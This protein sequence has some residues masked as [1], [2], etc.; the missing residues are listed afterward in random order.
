MAIKNQKLKKYIFSNTSSIIRSRGNAITVKDLIFNKDSGSAKAIVL[1]T[2]KYE[3]NFQGLNS[4]IILSS[5]TCPFDHGPVCKHEVAVANAIDT[6][7]NE[8]KVIQRT[9]KVKSKYSKNGVYVLF[10][11]TLEDLS[12][13]ILKKHATRTAFIDGTSSRDIKIDNIE[14]TYNVISAVVFDKSN[15]FETVYLTV[16][17]LVA[18]NE[19]RLTC[20]C[21]YLNKS[22][23]KHQITVLQLLKKEMIHF[24]YGVEKVNELRKEKLKEYGFS[25][26]NPKIEDF[27]EFCNTQKGI[28]VIPK[29]RGLM[30]LSE[31]NDFSEITNNLLNDEVITNLILPQKKK[32]N[33]KKQGIAI[34]VFLND[35]FSRRPEALTLVPLIG[36][37]NEKQELCTKISKIESNDYFID[38][39]KYSAE[40][41]FILE[42]V[43]SIT[44]E[45]L[46]NKSNLKD[47]YGGAKIII[48]VLKKLLPKLEG[49]CLYEI[50]KDYKISRADLRQIAIH[51][52]APELSFKLIEEEHFYVLESFIIIN[53][54]EV[55]L[56]KSETGDNFLLQQVKDDYYLVKSI[57]EAKTINFFK[58][59]SELRFLKSDYNNY[60]AKLIKPLSEKYNL[61]V[62]GLNQ[63]KQKVIS[64]MFKKQLFISVLDDFLIIKPAVGYLDETLLLSSK[65]QFEVTEKGVNFI[66]SRDIDF[67]TSFNEYI[68][69]LHPSFQNQDNE[70]FYLKEVE[71]IENT[72]FIGFFENLKVNNVEV[73]GL[74]NLKLKYNYNKPSISISVHSNIDWFDVNI[75]VS[76]GEEKVSLK[77]LKKSIIN[78]D[79]Y[80]RLKDGSIGILPEE[81]LEKYVHLFR[82]GEIKKE[83]IGVSKY[84]FSA[85][86]ILYED[87]QNENNL[88]DEYVIIKEKLAN[89]KAVKNVSQPKGLNAKLR[90]YQQEGLKWLNFLDDFKLGG[91]L[92]DDMGLGKTLQIISFIKHLKNKT[93]SK[94]PHLVI[95]PTSLIFNWNEEVK[96]FCPSLKV[97]T[98]SGSNRTKNT[99]EFKNYDIILTTYGTAINDISYLKKYHFNYIILDES[100]AIK[101]PISKR[102]KAVRLLKATNRL[103]LTGTPIENN[104][105][106]L[107]A[108]M[109]FVNPGLLGGMIHFKK[110]YATPIDKNKDKGVAK[111]LKSLI[112]P[113]L[114]R[115]TKNQVAK[116]LPPKT[117]QFLYCTM[118][119]EQRKLYE[120][121][122]NKYKDYLLGKIEDDGLG[123]SKIYVL[124]GLTKLRQICDSPSL[125]NDVEEY[126]NES[127]KI[128]ELISHI[129]H[130]TNNHKILIFSQ[131]VKMLKLIK[132]RLNALGIEYEYLDGK[133]KNRQ[134]K[135]HN[136]QNNDETRVF[137][138]SLKAGGTG[139]NLTAADYVYIVDPWWNPAVEAQAIDRCYRIGQQ[140]NVTAFKMIC[141]D[142]IEEKIVMHQQNKKE[143]SDNLIQTEDNFVKS[144]SK[145]AIQELFS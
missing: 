71:F 88:F 114:L 139:L 67:E 10:F 106:D 16:K 74:D 130:K 91:C 19:L 27:F 89:F 134:E 43:F 59:K 93:K 63:K 61:E 62:I 100:Q 11:N 34:G 135:V 121:Y 54:K 137:L 92:A 80:I 85:V 73:F 132:N 124:E 140:K 6:K 113:F 25:I 77:D 84:Q 60:D 17:V 96:K 66:V 5:C 118:G 58:K 127:V 42:A 2:S 14:K 111:E 1:G 3:V 75:T 81:W 115:R 129:T 101:N 68:K 40:E 51:R 53:G 50:K 108:Q 103:V 95:V 21:N 35:N 55:K 144:L 37:L 104:T 36:V 45:A 110:E 13:V 86:D 125:L 126:T 102:F 26:E 99:N 31:F 107:Y 142:T 98:L 44:E 46:Q 33:H 52:E 70:F 82:S 47:T 141:K 97:F 128:D 30:R 20:N 131:F 64:S 112:D 105:F 79:K 12:D 18:E 8:Q 65:K 72:W 133:T 22:L 57:A 24:L 143:V 117:E 9:P 87:L 78:K 7:L 41:Q 15:Y 136:F 4:E 56:S 90:P 119:K 138:I 69:S 94:I 28:E 29:K 122:K 49:Y 116:E 38:K 120:T 145:D 32:Q 23:C 39:E 83:R 109:T 48:N 123:K 76:F